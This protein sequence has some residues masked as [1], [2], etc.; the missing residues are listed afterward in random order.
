MWWLVG[1]VAV[2]VAWFVFRWFVPSP[3]ARSLMAMQDRMDQRSADFEAVQRGE[4]DPREFLRTWY[5]GC[6]I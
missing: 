2:S 5:P 6:G 3:Q 4:L 1:I